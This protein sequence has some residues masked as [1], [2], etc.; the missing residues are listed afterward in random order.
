MIFLKKVKASES[1]H[2]QLW[3]WFF[4]METIRRWVSPIFASPLCFSTFWC[5]SEFGIGNQLS[6]NELFDWRQCH[7]QSPSSYKMGIPLSFAHNFQAQSSQRIW[8]RWVWQ[9]PNNISFDMVESLFFWSRGIWV[10][11]SILNF[12]H[13]Q[14]HHVS[15]T[16]S[17]KQQK[18]KAP[19]LLQQRDILIY[20]QS[21]WLLWLWQFR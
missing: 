11:L 4:T 2:Q 10:F 6:R 1:F 16:I 8:F 9:Y 17:K 14:C 18:Q 20:T 19:L 5:D 7:R 3:F 13:I 21:R 15:E 12:F